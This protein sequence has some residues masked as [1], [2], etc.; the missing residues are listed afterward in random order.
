VNRRI[1]AAWGGTVAVM[2]VGHLI[3]GALAAYAAESTG[4][5]VARPGDLIL[6]WIIPGLLVVAT[7]RYTRRVVG[8]TSSSRVSAQVAG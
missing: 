8:E 5:L 4:Y 1:S 3:A 6:N 7:V 2:A